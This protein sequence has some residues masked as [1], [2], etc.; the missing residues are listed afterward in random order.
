MRAFFHFYSINKDKHHLILKHLGHLGNTLQLP[1]SLISVL[2][3]IFL[4]VLSIVHP[5]VCHFSSLQLFM[6]PC[7]LKAYPDGRN[8]CYKQYCQI[9]CLLVNAVEPLA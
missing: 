7:R 2:M 4:Y 1:L 3:I 6:V 8:C 5:P 9:N